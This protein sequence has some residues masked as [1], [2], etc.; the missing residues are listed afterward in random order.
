MTI[1][2]AS[3]PTISAIQKVQPW[4]DAQADKYIL[5]PVGAKGING[6]VFDYEGATTI[7]H[8]ATITDHWAEDNTVI[9]DHIAI[10]PVKITLHGYVGEQSINTSGGVNG[11]FAAL[12]SKLGTLTP[13]LNQYSTQMQSKLS[14]ALSKSQDTMNKLNRT[15]SQVGNALT[16]VNN[17][18]LGGLPG[19]L[20]K[21]DPSKKQLNAYT[22]LVGFFKTKTIFTLTTPYGPFD[23]MAIESLIFT[24]DAE[25]SAITDISVT[26]KQLQF[27]QVTYEAYNPQIFALRSGAERQRI[28]DLGDEKKKNKDPSAAYIGMFGYDTTYTDI[29]G[30]TGNGSGASGDW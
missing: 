13:Y 29:A 24:Q 23:N 2:P 20:S 7:S 1:N 19:L 21:S 6:F 3:N 17:V 5:G 18:G 25:T 30:T 27:A 9:N 8:N 4:L 15:V 12:Q 14:K 22:Q 26:L 11:A 16:L 10:S 28:K